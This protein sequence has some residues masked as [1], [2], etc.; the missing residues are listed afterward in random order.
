[1]I[2][3]IGTLCFIFMCAIGLQAQNF[4]GIIEMR[5]ETAAGVTYDITWYIKND[6]IA[7]EI[8]PHSG[9]KSLKMRFVPQPEQNSMLMIINSPE[10]NTKK[11]ILPH[12]ISSDID[13][14]NSTVS[15]IGT[16][17]SENF[18]EVKVLSVN[19]PTTSTEVEVTT[20]ININ[21]A[22]YASLIKNEYGIQAL[23]KTNRKGFPLNSVT[24]DSSGKV[25]SKTNVSSV[26][27]TSVSEEYFQ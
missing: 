22:K 1:M 12:D 13:M 10:G 9:E 3:L 21:L 16:R 20:A 17:N 26:N 15:E 14:S 7:Y 27:R 2:K 8:V 24:K 4:E 23:I 5:Q 11:E 6:R 25:V 18:G 19:T